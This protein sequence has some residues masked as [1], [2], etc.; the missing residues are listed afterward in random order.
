MTWSLSTAA[1]D[2]EI[3]DFHSYD[4]CLITPLNIR[5]SRQNY[6]KKLSEHI[7]KSIPPGK[8]WRIV[9]SLSKLNNKHTPLPPLKVNGQT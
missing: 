1:F 9:M 6:N 7:N 8:W 3:Q 5:S 2:E 4:I